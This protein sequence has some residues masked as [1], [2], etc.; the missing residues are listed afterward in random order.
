MRLKPE[1]E[2]ELAFRTGYVEA[3]SERGLDDELMNGYKAALEW[4]LEDE[5][6]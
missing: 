5:D 6:E 1:I 4:V 3:L 2:R